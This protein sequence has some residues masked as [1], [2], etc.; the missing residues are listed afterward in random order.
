ARERQESAVGIARRAQ[1]NQKGR[2]EGGPSTVPPREKD[3]STLEVDACACV[4]E[5]EAIQRHG[6]LGAVDVDQF[7]LGRSAATD[8]R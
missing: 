3:I 4:E 2:L 5:V 1:S 7:E 6:H 8:Q